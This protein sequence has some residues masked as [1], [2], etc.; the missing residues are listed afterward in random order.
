MNQGLTQHVVAFSIE[1]VQLPQLG[2]PLGHHLLGPVVGSGHS[3]GL[4]S[5]QCGQ[6]DVARPDSQQAAVLAGTAS[7][8]RGR[9]HAVGEGDDR[10]R[11]DGTQED[12]LGPSTAAAGDADSPGVDIRQIAQEIQATNRIPRL[13]THDALK[14]Q[15]GLGADEPPAGLRAV[16]L[17]TLFLQP[18][19]HAHANLLGVSVAFHVEDKGHT[20]HPG[21]RGT[22]SQLGKP[23]RLGELL[24]TAL[25]QRVHLRSTIVLQTAAVAMRTQDGWMLAASLLPRRTEQQP[26]DKM[27]R[28]TLEINLLDGESRPRH[29]AEDH[30]VHR[31][32]LGH[33][34]QPGRH[35]DPS[36][37]LALANFPRLQ[38]RG[39]LEGE[40][41]VEV[42]LRTQSAVVGSLTGGKSTRQGGPGGRNDQQGDRGGQ[43]QGGCTSEHQG[44]SSFGHQRV[45]LPTS[46][47][48]RKA[49][50]PRDWAFPTSRPNARRR[51]SHRRSCPA[52]PCPAES[53]GRRSP[54]RAASAPGGRCSNTRTRDT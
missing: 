41:G 54:S 51:S 35:Q 21:Q 47:P 28:D 34:P 52:T 13:Q 43:Q 19:R 27:T 31:R 48:S 3:L 45:R 46:E 36:L 4:G 24:G 11:I 38:C 42:F 12:R 2:I 22:A 32:S 25:D 39:D 8:H 15:F 6:L 50:P 14:S 9:D 20:A 49:E 5:K 7:L 37:Q 29:L 17:R 30:R 33:W 53:T 16:H 18:V 10:S 1:P 26:G 23:A 44:D 40:V